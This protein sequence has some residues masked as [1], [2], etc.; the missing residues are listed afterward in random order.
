MNRTNEKESYLNENYEFR[1]N[2]VLNRTFFKKK[3]TES[4]YELLDNYKRNSIK[5]E[6]DNNYISCNATDLKCLL[7][8]DFVKIYN[9]FIDYFHQLPKWD[10]KTDYIKKLT[11]TI[12]AVNQKDFEWAF[13][14]W[15]V[16]T[17][18]C[19]ID[20]EVTNQTVLIFTGKQGLGKTTWL[21]NL[22]PD[23][24][25]SYFYSGI[26][27]PTSKD[28]TLL[29]S[30][31]FIINFDELAS[32]NKKQIEVL[33]EMITK[34]MVTERRAYGEF[35]ENYIRRASFVGSSNHNEILMDVTGNRRFLCFEITDIDYM[36]NIDLD[37]V[38]SQVMHLIN[39]GEFR[40]YFNDEDIKRLEE[41]NK[42]YIQSSE[43]TDWIE[44]LF[45]LPEN[46]QQAEYFNA[47][48][49]LEHIKKV[50]RI[51]KNINV[52]EI[53]KIMT[54]LGYMTK[55]INGRKKYI[56]KLN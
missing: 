46:E 19:A 14:K 44:E 12:S 38:Y 7:N 43:E 56:V 6:L 47:S 53:G 13:K 28:S 39:Q 21:K 17:V 1:F 26:V 16:A 35:T 8:S 49:I 15:L 37:G 41:N 50:K 2:E 51:Y 55:K 31:K 3:N 25:K 36:H 11:E 9:P 45:S 22:T 52:Q 34:E 18:A 5:R 42:M 33:K 10:T 48:E 20:E 27:N 54:S 30:E 4:D 24:L 40:Y 32:L 23:V 29:L